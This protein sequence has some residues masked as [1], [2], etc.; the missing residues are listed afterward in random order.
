FGQYNTF[1]AVLPLNAPTSLFIRIYDAGG[2]L[3]N[4]AIA[5]LEIRPTALV[6]PLAIARADAAPGTTAQ[7]ADGLT[8]DTYNGAG[9]DPGPIITVNPGTATPGT[10]DARPDFLGFQ[11][12][13]DT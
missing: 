1:S 9:A 6:A 8:V 3:P 11:V 12:V 10:A 13:A 7:A 2:V 5:G 4:W